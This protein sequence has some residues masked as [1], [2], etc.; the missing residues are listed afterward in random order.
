MG[1]YR[2][3]V[4]DMTVLMCPGRLFFFCILFKKMIT[5]ATNMRLNFY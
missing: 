3:I 5:F 1:I 4:L 2:C